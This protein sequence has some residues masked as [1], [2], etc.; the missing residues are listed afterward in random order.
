VW[1]RYLQETARDRITFLSV[2]VDTN[3]ERARPYAAGYPFTTVVDSTGVLGRIFGFDVIP[4]GVLIDERGVIRHLHLGGFDIRR[5]EVAE[6]VTA[7]L[8]ADFATGA[9]PPFTQEPLDVETFRLELIDRPDD[10]GLLVALGDALVRAGDNVEAERV[11]R[12]AG[13]L[14]PSDWSSPFAVGTIL[15]G[16]GD[17]AGALDWWRRAL[18]RDPANFTI[19]K[20]IWRTEHPERFSPEIDFAWQKEQLAREGYRA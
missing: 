12:R 5:P 16:W 8:E 3:P 10:P 1:Q 11:F 15:E 6:R 7:L 4:N 20:Q 18:A 17:S 13:D 14:D 19:R 2:A 9:P